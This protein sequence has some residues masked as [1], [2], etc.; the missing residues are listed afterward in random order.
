MVGLGVI[1]NKDMDRGNTI[2]KD[3]V[4]QLK[5]EVGEWSPRI[6]K[7]QVDSIVSAA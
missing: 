5:G 2:D 1:E 4:R 6:F 7:T 3:T